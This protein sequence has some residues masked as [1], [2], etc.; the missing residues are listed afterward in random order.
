MDTTATARHRSGE[1]APDPLHVPG[2]ATD[3]LWY[4]AAHHLAPA[5]E[6]TRKRGW[7]EGFVAALEVLRGLDDPAVAEVLNESLRLDLEIAE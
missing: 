4:L 2:G 7:V 3:P 5:M 6:T 1:P